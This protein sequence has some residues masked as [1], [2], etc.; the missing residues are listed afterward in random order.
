MVDPDSGAL[1]PICSGC[2]LVAVGLRRALILLDLALTQSTGTL[3]LVDFDTLTRTKLADS[4]YAVAVD[5]GKS[6]T[7]PPGTDA[8]APGTQVAF[9]VRNRLLAPYDGLWVANLP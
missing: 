5:R 6:A 8:L 1:Q 9:L 2:T 7:I 3:G 4:V